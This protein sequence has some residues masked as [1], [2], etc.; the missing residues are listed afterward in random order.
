M[1]EKLTFGM[2]LVYIFW[3]ARYLCYF[4]LMQRRFAAWSFR[5]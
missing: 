3:N 1:I 5:S 2:F 4:K